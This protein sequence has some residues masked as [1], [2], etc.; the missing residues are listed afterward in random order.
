MGLAQNA[1]DEL[2]DDREEILA[3][4]THL[5]RMLHVGSYDTKG[6]FERELG[7]LTMLWDRD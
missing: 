2:L 5:S 4:E 7:A 1:S 6:N 3:W